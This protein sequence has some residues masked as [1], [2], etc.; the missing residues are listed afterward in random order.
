MYVRDEEGHDFLSWEA[1]NAHGQE[2]EGEK[3]KEVA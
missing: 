1:D 2:E 3:K